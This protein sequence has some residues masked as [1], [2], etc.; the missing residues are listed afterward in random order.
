M[1][2]ELTYKE[3]YD[4]QHGLK[5]KGPKVTPKNADLILADVS[6]SMGMAAFE[7]KTRIDCVRLALKPFV[8]RAH[9]LAFDHRVMEVD[10]DQIPG[11]GGS[12]GLDRAI[13]RAIYLEPIHV[14]VMCDGCPDLRARSLEMAAKLAEQCL[15]DALY[16]GPATDEAAIAFMKELAAVGHGRFS[17]FSLTESSP[18]LLEQKVGSLLALPDPNSVVK[19]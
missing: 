1:G 6:G 9:V 13:E 7:G 12:T 8:G 3:R 11:A 4:I 17:M 14:L 5:P 2:R 19:L 10:C 16:I 15:I 18:L